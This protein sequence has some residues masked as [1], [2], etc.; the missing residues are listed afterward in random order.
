MLDEDEHE[1]FA[2]FEADND[3]SH[4]TLEPLDL[5]EIRASVGEFVE[6]DSVLV[7]L[8]EEGKA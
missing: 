3:S 4:D 2:A 6:A 1:H 5:S 8:V 7:R